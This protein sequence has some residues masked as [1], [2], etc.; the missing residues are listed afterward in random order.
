MGCCAPR[1]LLVLVVGLAVLSAS[2]AAADDGADCSQRY[3]EE[4]FDA[5]IAAYTRA[6]ASGRYR[7]RA[8]VNAHLTRAL[9]QTAKDEHDR[10]IAD[11][12]AAI[13]L[14]PTR[15]AA[16]QGRGESHLAQGNQE[17]ALPDL[18][19]AIRLDP[20]SV[21]AFVYRGVILG[22]RGEHDRAIIDFTA[23]IQLEP[24][25]AEL[26]ARRA[27]ARASCGRRRS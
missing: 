25:S 7:G 3:E 10:A 21:T 8:L 17:R 18:N 16:Y 9:S 27:D 6:I 13:R 26:R 2:P 5:A 23:A 15:A 11:F 12:T 22:A 4:K 1:P 20:K 19:E 14:D 24:F